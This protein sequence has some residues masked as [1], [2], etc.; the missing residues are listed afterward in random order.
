MFT[1]PGNPVMDGGSVFLTCLGGSFIN[2]TFKP[3]MFRFDAWLFWLL[4]WLLKGI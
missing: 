3:A 1:S 4:H 2:S